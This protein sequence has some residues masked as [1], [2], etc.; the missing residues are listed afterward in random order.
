M[1]EETAMQLQLID[2]ALKQTARKLHIIRHQPV[3]PTKR[4]LDEA[5]HL[6]ASAM[7]HLCEV[8]SF[9]ES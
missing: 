2:D 9:A 5:I 6:L 4:D 8:A 1:D 3:T 7:F